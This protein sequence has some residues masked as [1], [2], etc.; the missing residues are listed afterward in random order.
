MLPG[1][2][3]IKAGNGKN[4]GYPRLRENRS[5]KGV[6]E[7]VLFGEGLVDGSVWN[8]GLVGKGISQR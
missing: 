8:E 5:E 2:V 1:R 4:E 7:P 6:I 3:Y